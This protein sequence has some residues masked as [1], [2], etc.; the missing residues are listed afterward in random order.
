MQ[1]FWRHLLSDFYYFIKAA[2]RLIKNRKKKWSGLFKFPLV[3]KLL[4]HKSCNYYFYGSLSLR[5]RKNQHLINVNWIK[6]DVI[7]TLGMLSTQFYVNFSLFMEK[8]TLI[9]FAFLIKWHF[10]G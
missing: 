8:L 3:L 7:V 5:Y 6:I 1:N 10:S 2:R 4:S 9:V